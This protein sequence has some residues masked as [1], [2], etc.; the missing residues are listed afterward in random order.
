M[1]TYHKFSLRWALS[2]VK[3]ILFPLISTPIALFIVTNWVQQVQKMR[4]TTSLFDSLCVQRKFGK[5]SGEHH[6]GR[7]TRLCG[8]TLN[9]FLGS[10]YWNLKSLLV[11]SGCKIRWR[12]Q[13]N[14]SVWDRFDKRMLP[15][16][17]LMAHKRSNKKL[18]STSS[19]QRGGK[20]HMTISISCKAATKASWSFTSTCSFLVPGGRP[21]VSELGL[22]R[23]V[24]GAPLPARAATIAE[25]AQPLWPYIAIL[26]YAMVGL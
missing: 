6:C 3:M 4:R 18:K 7:D 13:L 14:I 1:G 5:I 10:I 23:T 2:P 22:C 17:T 8:C 19:L 9:P 15:L 26:L 16:D 11:V 24:T 25:L 20:A 21:L 12:E